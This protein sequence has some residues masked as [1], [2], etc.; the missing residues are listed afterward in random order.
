MKKILSI[1]LLLSLIFLY[2]CSTP[3]STTTSTSNQ[4][5]DNQLFE[6]KQECAGYYNQVLDETKSNR[7][8][9]KKFEISE[10]FYSPTRNSCIWVVCSSE[11]IANSNLLITECWIYDI[12]NK[13]REMTETYCVWWTECNKIDDENTIKNREIF[14]KHLAELKWE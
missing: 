6:K 14:N 10:I 4:Q 13:K 1:S 9:E 12:L 11:K 8:I 2:G 5:I 3:T 7:W